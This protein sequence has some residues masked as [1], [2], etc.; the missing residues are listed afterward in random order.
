MDEDADKIEMEIEIEMD[1]I[2]QY[3]MIAV[4]IINSFKPTKRLDVSKERIF[5]QTTRFANKKNYK[6]KPH[7]EISTII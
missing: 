3:I 2:N 6:K 1:M 7:S 5:I 4:V